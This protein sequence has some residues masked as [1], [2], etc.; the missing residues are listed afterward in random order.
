MAAEGMNVPGYWMNETS[1]VLRPAIE[2]YL[3]DREHLTDSEIAALRAY[4]RQ[5]ME[6]DFQGGVADLLRAKVDVIKTTQDIE[7]WL[8]LAMEAGIDPL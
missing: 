6:G 1:G 8:W 5:W 7:A 3:I 2:R 4:F